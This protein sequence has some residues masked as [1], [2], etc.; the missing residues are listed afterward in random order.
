MI[1]RL[2]RLSLPLNCFICLLICQKWSALHDQVRSV[3]KDYPG[4]RLTRGRKVRRSTLFVFKCLSFF[5]IKI[6]YMVINI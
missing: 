6:N 3:L 2:L 1:T 4:L 5:S